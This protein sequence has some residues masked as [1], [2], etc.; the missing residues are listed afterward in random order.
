MIGVHGSDGIRE[1]LIEAV[2]SGD[3]HLLAQL[4]AKHQVTI[5]RDFTTWTRVPVE[6]R[7]DPAAVQRYANGLIG[8]AQFFATQLGDPALLNAI[9]GPQ[10]SNPIVLWQRA[11]GQAH[12]LMGQSRYGDAR[13]VLA[14]ALANASGVQGTAVDSLLPLTQGKLGECCFQL[15]DAAEALEPTAIALRLCQ[16]QGDQ[17]GIVAYLGNLFEIHRYLG[18]AEPAAASAERYAEVLMAAGQARAAAAWRQHAQLVRAGEPLNRVAV[19]VGGDEYELDD[20]P[21]VRDQ[22]V[23]F[24]FKRNRRTLEPSSLRTG[25]GE[26]LGSQGRHDEAYASFKEAARLD[27]FN[28]HPRYLSGLTLLHMGRYAEAV[29]EYEATER[30]APGWFNCRADLWA[31]RELERGAIDHNL[32]QMLYVLEDAPAPPQEKVRLAEGALRLAPRL[33]PLH[34]FH[35]KNLEQLGATSAAEA[36]YRN[37]LDCATEPDI[38]TRLL[39]ALGIASPSAPQRAE[40]LVEA[41]ATIG[42]NLVASAM[43]TIA[44][45]SA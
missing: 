9:V 19:M 8:L 15:G 16:E 39:V 13:Q 31:A 32:F 12:E 11:L 10:E 43:A 4:C 30:L 7:A 37:G 28:P 35:G 2:S 23:Q 25:E 18:Q 41:A 42:G 44:L 1:A 14:A 26:R 5:R 38:R 6:L 21:A 33:A 29:A 45:R 22:Q 27:P 3:H 36:A 17:D 24:I 40:L 20:L 34:L